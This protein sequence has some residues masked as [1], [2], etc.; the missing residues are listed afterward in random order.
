[1]KHYTDDPEMG[2][3]YPNDG[4]RVRLRGIGDIDGRTKAAKR[5]HRLVADIISDLGGDVALSAAQ[6]ELAQRGALLGAIIADIEARW[7]EDHRVDLGL[8]GSLVDRQRRVLESLG[9]QR[10]PRQ[11]D[12]AE[13]GQKLIDMVR[14]V[15]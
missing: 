7:L 2:W 14:E 9:L 13:L 11:I 15:S 4:G 1:M 6:R 10:T 8:Y 3:T 12:G 5:A